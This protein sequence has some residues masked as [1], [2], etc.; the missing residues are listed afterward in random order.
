M[1][2]EFSYRRNSY[3]KNLRSLFFCK[4]FLPSK[5]TFFPDDI[6]RLS[7]WNKVENFHHVLSKLGNMETNWVQNFAC[8]KLTHYD[9]QIYLSHSLKLPHW[10]IKCQKKN[11]HKKTR[12][13]CDYFFNWLMKIFLTLWGFF[14]RENEI[15]SVPCSFTH[16]AAWEPHQKVPKIPH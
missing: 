4:G 13:N 6:L 15:F 3:L 12:E 8:D 5:L 2:V 16:C 10:S 11:K 9:R 7:G 14:T 1:C